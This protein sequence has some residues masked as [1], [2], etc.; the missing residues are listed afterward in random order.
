[1][2][3]RRALAVQEALHA[4]AVAA[5]ED[6]GA[7]ILLVEH[8]SVLTLGKHADPK[9]LGFAR[10]HFAARGIDIVPIDRGGEVTAHEPGQLVMYPVLR[11]DAF[12]LG[13]RA[14]VELLED[15][16][17]AT[18]AGLGITAAR[19]PRYPG[20]WVGPNKICAIG[21][22]IKDRVTMHGIAL[23]VANSMALFSEIVPCGIVG[24][25]V[26]SVERQLGRSIDLAAVRARIVD[27]T[28]TR[29]MHR[30]AGDAPEGED[31]PAPVL[32]CSADALMIRI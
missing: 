5:G 3:Y 30:L 12:R 4:R 18:L 29:L 13:A 19:D 28:A 22:R 27:E 11:L 16:V 26:T 15:A 31:R 32:Q 23:N 7:T 10:E 2:E 21:I 6:A 24:R 1:M 20:V 8:P 25:G 9:F 14:Y 17:I